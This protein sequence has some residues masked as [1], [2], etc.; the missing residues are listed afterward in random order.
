M[1]KIRVEGTP[2]NVQT[3]ATWQKGFDKEMQEK[4]DEAAKLAVK[5]KGKIRQTV[6]VTTP[7]RELFANNLVSITS[8][9]IEEG[10]MKVDE[11]EEGKFTYKS[12]G[13]SRKILLHAL[14]PD[15]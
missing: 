15:I 14:V 12:T 1:R 5:G 7:G 13:K 3:F 6:R 10:E 9:E 11:E 4:A 2:V 8:D